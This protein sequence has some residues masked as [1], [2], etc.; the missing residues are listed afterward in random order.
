LTLHL[1]LYQQWFLEILEGTK[2]IE[3]RR[4]CPHWDKK[5]TSHSYNRVHF[6]NG[7]GAARPWMECE[8]EK[9]KFHFSNYEGNGQWE[10][11]LGRILETG[12]L[13]LLEKEEKS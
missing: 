5:F 13:E 3:Y 4:R 11:H 8:I 7:Y 10:I 9:I 1:S 12:N 2:K 6:V